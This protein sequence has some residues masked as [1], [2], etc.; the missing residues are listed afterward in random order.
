MAFKKQQPQVY[1]EENSL[2][3]EEIKE[4]EKEL[5]P[6]Y[7]RN[8]RLFN[9]RNI[10]GFESYLHNKGFFRYS[11]RYPSGAVVAENVDEYRKV[12]VKFNALQDLW[13][14]RG[15]AQAEDERRLQTLKI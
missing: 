7:K 6:Y 8:T 4:F 11:L 5:E 12:K 1:Q 15:K 9:G 14:R 2:S 10:T 3:N 13:D